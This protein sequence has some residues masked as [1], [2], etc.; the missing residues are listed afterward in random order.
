M[1][2]LSYIVPVYRVEKYLTKCVESLL[3]QGFIENEYE[4][5]LVDDGSDDN[6]PAL[7]DHY[8][9]QYPQIRVIHQEN[10]GLSGARNTGI[11][12]AKGNYFCFVDS[13]DY[14]ED[15]SYS[16][17]LKK[18]EE[19]NA[20]L[21]QFGLQI[22][23]DH[24]CKVIRANRDQ[25]VY[26]GEEFLTIKMSE[27]C[28]C[29]IYLVR[30]QLVI[31][32]A[33]YFTEGITYEDIDWTPRMVLQAKKIVCVPDIVYNY[34][35]HSESITHP[36]DKTGWESIIANNIR[37]L[38]LLRQTSEKA[39]LSKSWFNA[40]MSSILC[41]IWTIVAKH[42]YTERDKYIQEM[43]S[44]YPIRLTSMPAFSRRERIKIAIARISPKLYCLI[45]HYL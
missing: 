35:Q 6:C 1:I 12:N 29:C 18:A 14:V 26:T 37:V 19:E 5:I 30:R 41:A 44:A 40:M 43:Q 24:S 39:S 42:V 31:D 25:H 33:T 17:V 9:E 36:K 8:A 28:S 15:F 32:T 34:V 13:D 20:D 2:R 3:H 27:R 10:K 45:R 23:Q 16:A 21:L 38:N 4:I 22:V 11:R 7:C